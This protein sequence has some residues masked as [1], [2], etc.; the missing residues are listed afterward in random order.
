M[1]KEIWKDILGFEGIY[2][3]SNL[4]RVKSLGRYSVQKHWIDEKI[5]NVFYKK[6]GYADVSLYLDGKRVHKYVHKLV[7]EAFLPNPNNLPEVDHKNRNPKDNRVENLRWCTHKGNYENQLTRKQMK[8]AQTG[9]KL[10]EKQIENMSKKIDVFFNGELLYT[11]K[12]Y[13]DLDDNSDKIIGTKLWNVYAREVI[14]GKRK[15]YK[16]F[17]FAEHKGDD[18]A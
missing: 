5:L 12:S 8:I 17:T 15:H 10:S 18:D 16:G 9:K 1:E 13:R 2:Q 3:I 7:A 14:K 6:Y 11:F 4:G